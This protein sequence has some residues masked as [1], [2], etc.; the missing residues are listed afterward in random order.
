M[1]LSSVV[2]TKWEQ[3]DEKPTTVI[4]GLAAFVTLWAASGLLDSV[5]RLPLAGG[6]FEVCVSPAPHRSPISMTHKPCVVLIVHCLVCP[7]V[8]QCQVAGSDRTKNGFAWSVFYG[9]PHVRRG[10]LLLALLVARYTRSF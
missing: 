3:N 2:Q 5:N 10:A 8:M 7:L 9:Q 4:L 6:F 1:F